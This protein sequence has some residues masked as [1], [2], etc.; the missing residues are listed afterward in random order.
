MDFLSDQDV[1]SWSQIH[2]SSDSMSLAKSCMLE[3]IRLGII[4]LLAEVT[5][6]DACK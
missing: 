5:T 2:R 3:C 6:N 4:S 1:G